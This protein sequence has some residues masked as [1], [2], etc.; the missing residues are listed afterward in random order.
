MHKG[1]NGY[2]NHN[3]CK[4]F[5]RQFYALT[6]ILIGVCLFFVLRSSFTKCCYKCILRKC[7]GL[8]VAN[9]INSVSKSD[10]EKSLYN[11][12]K[13]MFSCSFSERIIYQV[14][15]IRP[16]NNTEHQTRH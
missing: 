1:G 8:G 4:L 2:N 11:P 9:L 14:A 10:E 5:S 7:R 3:L 6:I 13:I 16:K 12:K 15:K